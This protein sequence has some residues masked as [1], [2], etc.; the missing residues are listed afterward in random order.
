MR[1]TIVIDKSRIPT[2]RNTLEAFAGI[3]TLP[4]DDFRFRAYRLRAMSLL[5]R[6][7][8]HTDLTTELSVWRGGIN[9]WIA[10]RSATP[11]NSAG[12]PGGAFRLVQPYFVTTGERILLATASARKRFN[13]H[14]PGTSGPVF[15]NGSDLIAM[16]RP[17]L[18]TPQSVLIDGDVT[19]TFEIEAVR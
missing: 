19:G 15:R 7:Q 5:F 1:F 6:C 16:M 4:A 9:A 8:S 3:T 17:K 12:P 10:I 11:T 14:W 18:A 2:T 13:K